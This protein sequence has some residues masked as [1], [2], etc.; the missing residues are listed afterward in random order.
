MWDRYDPQ[1]DDVKRGGSWDRD[2]GSRGGTTERHRNEEPDTRGVFTKDLDLPRGR[3][4]QPV[5]ERDRIYEINGTE[6]RMLGTIGAFRVVSESDVQ[7]LRDDS[8]NTRRSLRHLEDEGLIRRTSLSSDDRA[9]VLTQRGRDLLEANRYERDDR[10]HEPRQTFYAGLKK[11][12]ELTHDTKVYRVGLRAQTGL[13]TV[14][15]GAQ[16]R[17]K[18]R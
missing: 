12:R 13:P 6:S 9:G 17:P 2:F 16:S 11:P 15:S 4:R 7:D 18:G 5:R 10:A 8:S 14:P 1:S 3:E